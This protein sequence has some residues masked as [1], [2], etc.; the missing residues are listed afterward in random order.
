MTALPKPVKLTAEQRKAARAKA[1]RRKRAAAPM[2]ACELEKL[3]DELHSVWLRAARIGCEMAGWPHRATTCGGWG[4]L[5]AALQCAHGWDRGSKAVRFDPSNTFSICAHCHVKYTRNH[6][7]GDAQWHDWMAQ[8]LGEGIYQ[9]LRQRARPLRQWAPWEL[10]EVIEERL[11][12]ISE[13]PDTLR[14]EWAQG[15]VASMAARIRKARQVRR[16]EA[17]A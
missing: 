1:R 8:R 5:P 4:M 12:W 10:L 13:M 9:E 3:A 17:A 6:R 16:E 7:Q 2:P 11:R 14:K 15:R